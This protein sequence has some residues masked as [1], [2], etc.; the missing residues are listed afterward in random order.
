[1]ITIGLTLEQLGIIDLI[2]T[3]Y[4]R[5]LNKNDFETASVSGEV[6]STYLRTH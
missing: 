5:P 3:M 2:V 4:P 6:F 1:M